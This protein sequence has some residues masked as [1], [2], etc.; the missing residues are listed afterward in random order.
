MR[1]KSARRVHAALGLPRSYVRPPGGAAAAAPSPLWRPGI[2]AAK[3][4][5]A[6][7]GKMR[8]CLQKVEAVSKDASDIFDKCPDPESGARPFHEAALDKTIGVEVI[9]KSIIPKF[10][11]GT[12]AAKR[13]LVF[14]TNAE[15]GDL[16]SS[17]LA[18]S[19]GLARRLKATVGL[20]ALLVTIDECE[21]MGRADG[22]KEC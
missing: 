22:L 17:V 18:T 13:A 12:A 7:Q 5:A 2:S 14:E 16:A 8:E 11:K 6:T 15:K 1:V 19:G 3:V 4:E 9:A 10:E 21:E 20:H